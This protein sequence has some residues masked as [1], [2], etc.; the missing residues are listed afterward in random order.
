MTTTRVRQLTRRGVPK[1]EGG[2]WMKLASL[3]SLGFVMWQ[4]NFHYDMKDFDASG[5]KSG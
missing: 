5:V 4:S 2:D 1:K 3:I